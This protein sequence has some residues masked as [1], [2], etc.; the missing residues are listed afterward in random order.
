VARAASPS[1]DLVLKEETASTND[2]ARDLALAGAPEGAAVLARAQSGGRGR[3]GRA[4]ASPPGGLYLSVVLRPR[5]P[6]ASWSLLP[7]LAGVVV[8]RVLRERGFADV[9]VKWPNDLVL[10]AAKVGGILVESRFG[11]GPPFAVA[12]MG[13]NLLAAPVP[14]ATSLSAHG[15]APERVA[16]ARELRDALVERTRAW[17]RAGSDAQVLRDVRATCSTLGREVRWNEKESGR[18]VDVAED[19]ALVVERSDGSTARLR[20]DDVRLRVV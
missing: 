5:V 18:A 19:G 11:A 17:A 8:A 6:P 1:V 4:F 3:L 15:L 16:L 12:G 10:G 7:L 9:R 13:L 20:A 14:E 2:D